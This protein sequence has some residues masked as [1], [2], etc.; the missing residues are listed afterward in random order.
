MRILKGLTVCLL[1]CLLA[2]PALATEGDDSFFGGSV[3]K[4]VPD[5]TAQPAPATQRPERVLKA[6]SQP[7][8][9][10]PVEPAVLPV[11]EP[12]DDPLAPTGEWVYP[13]AYDTLMKDK[14]GYVKLVNP[15]N[16]LDA[17]YKPKDLVK[18][19]VRKTSS[20]PIQLRKVCSEALDM[21]FDDANTQGIT[22]YLLSGYRSYQ[23]QNT[24][25]HNRLDNNNG[26]DDKAVAYPGASDHQTG[27]G[28]DVINKASIDSKLS[29]TFLGSKEALWLAE[30]CWEYGFIIRYPQEKSDIT[31]IIYEPWHLRYVGVDVAAYIMNNGMCLEEFTTEWQGAVTD[32]DGTR[33][34]EPTE[35]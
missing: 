1:I 8:V 32:Y 6:Q 33:F 29:T 31:G 28:A 18:T 12:Q 10:E 9:E 27:L 3:P 14:E 17:K 34:G 35:Y 7:A 15:D 4:A 25:Y 19:R 23:T 24:M 21:L 2:L 30:H 26:V 22:L 5:P 13:I 16:M 11:E 20:D